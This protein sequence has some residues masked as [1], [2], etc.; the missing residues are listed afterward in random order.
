[1]NRFAAAHDVIST[2]VFDGFDCW[3]MEL[4][5]WHDVFVIVIGFTDYIGGRRLMV[6]RS[7]DPFSILPAG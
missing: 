4:F 2:G 1:M 3:W 6:A 5:F 7:A